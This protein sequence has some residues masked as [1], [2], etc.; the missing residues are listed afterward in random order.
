M[1]L[2]LVAGGALKAYGYIKEDQI[3]E[4]Q[5]KF[6]KQVG[7]RNLQV[8]RANQRNIEAAAK[9]DQEAYERQA[10]AEMDAAEIEEKRVARKE[11]LVKAAQRAVVGKSG[12]GLAGA[13]LNVLA[14]TAFQ[15][16]LDRNLILRRGLI[17]SRE[18]L[19][20]GEMAL[21]RGRVLGRQE[22]FRGQLSYAQGKWASTLGKQAKQLSY[23]K[24]G[25]SILATA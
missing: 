17:R 21:F 15:F 13:T 20:A 1:S 16:S 2:L 9:A 5:G 10:K 11:K 19:Y 14:D 7:A 24:A 18:L 6:A 3:V 4:A 23:I 12:I 8:A 22:L 25:T